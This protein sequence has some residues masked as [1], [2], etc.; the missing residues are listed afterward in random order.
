MARGVGGG[1]GF[2]VT[3]SVPRY[4]KRE[5]LISFMLQIHDSN[6]MHTEP[7]LYGLVE[8]VF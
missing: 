1:V 7:T 8:I 4:V 3:I 6:R 2:I 5:D